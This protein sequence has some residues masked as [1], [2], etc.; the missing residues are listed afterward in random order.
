MQ[1]TV[2]KTYS[3]RGRFEKRISCLETEKKM[4]PA[5]SYC[6]DPDQE[7]MFLAKT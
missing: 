5:P 4:G 3:K 2:C 7:M 6:C 1:I